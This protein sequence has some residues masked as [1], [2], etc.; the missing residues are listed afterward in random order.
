MSV[1]VKSV[2]ILDCQWIPFKP[3]AASYLSVYLLKENPITRTRVGFFC[4]LGNAAV[5]FRDVR[6][7]GGFQYVRP[8]W[9][10]ARS[11]GGGG[12]G[13]AMRPLK[14]WMHLLEIRK[15]LNINMPISTMKPWFTLPH[16]HVASVEPP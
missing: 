15:I 6:F 4:P 9:L 14:I 5:R 10:H 1:T 12:Q 2:V 8:C 3:K 13:D 7:S 11:R 16:P